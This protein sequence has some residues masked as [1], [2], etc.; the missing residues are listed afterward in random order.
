MSRLLFAGML[1]VA[2]SPAWS[3]D[4]EPEWH[5]MLVT[6]VFVSGNSSRSDPAGYTVYSGIGLS[7]AVRRYVG[8]LL[9]VELSA[10][11]ESREVDVSQPTGPDLRLGS[12]D[13]LPVNL[14]LELRAPLRGSIRP[15]AGAGVNLTLAWEK[16]GV[17][18]PMDVSA[19]IGPAIQLGSDFALSPRI[20][21]NLDVK[22]NT[23][24]PRVSSANAPVVTLKVDPLLLSTGIG[25]AF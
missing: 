16:T 25:F 4:T 19:E 13:L 8:R 18:D 10:R 15:Y 22:W 3:Q 23:Y 2:A 11:T 20:V 12:L 5:G 14:V 21:L 1:L 6:S 24:R 17:L 9:A 7:A